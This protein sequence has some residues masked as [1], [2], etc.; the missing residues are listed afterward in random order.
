MH[1]ISLVSD[2]D[3]DDSGDADGEKTFP[4]RTTIEDFTE[5]IDEARFVRQYSF[6]HLLMRMLC[7]RQASCEPFT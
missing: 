6:F 3:V 7:L 2:A 1:P 4:N 5:E